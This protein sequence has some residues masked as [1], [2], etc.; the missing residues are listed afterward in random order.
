MDNE[1][2]Y[3]RIDAKSDDPV[4]DW[5]ARNPGRK[6]P[7]RPPARQIKDPI[8]CPMCSQT[9]RCPRNVDPEEFLLKKNRLCLVSSDPICV[10][11]TSN[12]TYASYIERLRKSDKP[13]SGQ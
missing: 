2:N 7:T 10:R 11:A 4:D 1:E 6:P 5:R 9:L 13:S 3:V 8:G 12:P